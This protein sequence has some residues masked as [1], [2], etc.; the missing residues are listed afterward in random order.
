MEQLW[1]FY[2]NLFWTELTET[3]NNDAC[4]QIAKSEG[5]ADSI[6]SEK[7]HPVTQTETNIWQR[8]K[9]AFQKLQRD[10]IDKKNYIPE[11]A[12]RQ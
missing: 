11:I 2:S 4:Y 6:Q 9:I 10:V 5:E 8:L 3:V 1:I 12:P 7:S